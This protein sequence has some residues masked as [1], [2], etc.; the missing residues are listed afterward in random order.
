MSSR[1]RLPPRHTAMFELLVPL[2]LGDVT[3]GWVTAAVQFVLQAGPFAVGS[4]DCPRVFGS[5]GFTRWEAILAK[6]RHSPGVYTSKESE[7][8][9]K[10]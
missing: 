8:V 3:G 4:K 10:T 6:A 9:I 2:P 7:L 1:T 5:T